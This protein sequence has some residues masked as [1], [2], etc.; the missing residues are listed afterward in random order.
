MGV[1][2]L[3][4]SFGFQRLGVIHA[5]VYMY[6]MPV[7]AVALSAVFFGDPLTPA[8]ILGGLTVLLGVILTRVA[9]DRA[10]RP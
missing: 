3:G 10:T 7:A 4:L 5:M 1:A 9:L 6:F 8:R 2:F